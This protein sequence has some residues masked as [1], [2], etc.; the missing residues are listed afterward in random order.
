MVTV[1][2]DLYVSVLPSTQSLTITKPVEFA[3]LDSTALVASSIHAQEVPTHRLRVCL[4]AINV[5]QASTAIIAKALLLH[6]LA[7][8]VTIVLQEL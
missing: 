3:H 1:T 7:Q 2:Q 4:F 8:L 5:L 6:F